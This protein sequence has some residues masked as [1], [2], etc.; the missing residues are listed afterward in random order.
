MN[1]SLYLISECG[2]NYVLLGQIQTDDL[3][4]RFGAYRKQTGGKSLISTSD[5]MHTEK[6]YAHFW[7]TQFSDIRGTQS[8]IAS[9][10]DSDLEV[11]KTKFCEFYMENIP[12][13]ETEL[14]T[15]L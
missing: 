11:I 2:F 7:N 6:H 4:K 15:K 13:N 14:L 10:L 12:V 9:D 8:D 3:E 1:L 5:I